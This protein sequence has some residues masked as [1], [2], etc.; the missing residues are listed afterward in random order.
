MAFIP[1]PFLRLTLFL[2]GGIVLYLYHPYIIPVSFFLPLLIVSFVLF[3]TAYVLNRKSKHTIIP[4][5]IIILPALVLAG[6]ML[7]FHKNDSTNQDHFMHQSDSTNYYRVV[8]TESPREGRKSWKAKG[9]VTAV[10]NQKQ[11]V[12]TTGNVLLYFS[13]D[14]FNQPPRYGDVFIINK[15]PL[16]IPPPGNPGEFDYRKFLSFQQVYHQYF[17][18]QQDVRYVSHEPPS[19][20]INLAIHLREWAEQTLKKHIQ[21]EEEKSVAIALVLGI[22]DELD[23]EIINA[24]AASGALHVLAVSG[25]H[26]GIV[27]IILMYIGKPLQKNKYGNVVLA[28]SV[29]L[30]LW[31]YACVTGLSP[32]V[33][34]AV[35]MFSIMA[36]AKLINRKGNIYN[37]LAATVFCLLMYNPYLLVSVG[38]QLSFIAVLG[39]VY[40]H[41]KLFSIIEFKNLVLHKTW[42]ITSISIAAQLAT[43]TLGLLYFHQFPNYFL[44]SNLVV[45]P[46]SSAILI[47]GI[48]LLA[49]SF[50]DAL[51]GMLGVLMHW[52]IKGLNSFVYWVET[53]PYSIVSHVYISTEQFWLATGVVIF[54]LLTLTMKKFHFSALALFCALGFTLLQWRQQQ[55]QMGRTQFIVYNVKGFTAIDFIGG[56][57]S[58]TCM[59]STLAADANAIRFHIRPHRMMSDATTNHPAYNTLPLRETSYGTLIQF[60][61]KNFLWRNKDNLSIP[62]QA[63]PVD[64]VIFSHQKEKHYTAIQSALPHAVCIFDSSNSIN[65]INRITESIQSH[66]DMYSVPHLGAFQQNL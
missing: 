39:I 54:L 15:K 63:V 14:E 18:K 31:L 55:H 66:T 56:G 6:Y 35:A 53:L 11:W 22:T 10:R 25:L 17:I 1:Y 58:Y 65:Y 48:G 7:T 3:V 19:V 13:H 59:D 12:E 24:Y 16:P 49:I 47:G 26:I 4:T 37:T 45:I 46:A 52:L 9:K 34:R 44:V 23:S 32:S 43:F 30:L 8:I 33:L 40:I 36:V 2:T 27:Y 41:T 38:F 62:P 57:Q 21:G 42:E 28:L 5:G 51:A 29:L 20:I 61:N 50:I 60:G 64:F